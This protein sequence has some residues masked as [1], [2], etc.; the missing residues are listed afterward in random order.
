[1]SGVIRRPGL[2]ESILH[3][4]MT[5]QISKVGI[6]R[7]VGCSEAYV[8]AVVRGINRPSAVPITPDYETVTTRDVLEA[9]FAF[10]QLSMIELA[11][12]LRADPEQVK[13]IC[14]ARALP[15]NARSL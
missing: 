13:R 10:P 5:T 1:M 2:K 15:F 9:Y 6:S 4:W 8:H 12:R 7:E 11:H 3:L 14:A